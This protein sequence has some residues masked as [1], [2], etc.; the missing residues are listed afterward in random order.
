MAYEHPSV[1]GAYDRNAAFPQ[2]A[3]LVHKAGDFVQAA[4]ANEAQSIMRRRIQRVGDM[5]ARDGDR[6]SGAQVSIDVETGRIILAAGKIYAAGDM[7][8]VPERI[9]EDVDLEGEVSIGIRIV[10]SYLDGD[11]L[12]ALR[13]LHPGSKA[14]GE[15]GAAR[16]VPTVAWSLRSLTE[17]GDYYQVYVA[18]DGTVID[19]TGPSSLATINQQ[20]AAKDVLVTGGNYIATGCIVTA[21]GQ[22]GSSMHFSVSEGVASI[23]GNTRTRTAA[24]RY[25]EPIE[26][27]VAQVGAEPH[28][29]DDGGTGTATIRLLNGP[30][31]AVNAVTVVKRAT[32]TIVRGPVAGTSDPLPHPSVQTIEL[33]VQGAT[34]FATSA[35]TRDG[36][37]ISWAPAGAEPA[38]GS[39][40]TATYTYLETVAPTTIGLDDIVVSGGVTG[41]TVLVNYHWKLP[42]IDRLCLNQ[43]GD[44]LY[45]RGVSARNPK[46]PI[47]PADVLGLADI[48]NDWRGAPIVVNN[49]TAA[50][51]LPMLWRFIDLVLRNADTLALA[52]LEQD[53]DQREPVA[54]NGMFVD[55]LDNDDYR[56]AGVP[57]TAAI[58]DNEIRLAI[59]PTI[60]TVPMT[61]P[62]LLP[63]VDELIIDQPFVTSC[64]KINPY[65]NF[66]PLP[67]KL[68]LTPAVDMW[69][70]TRTEWLS[71]RTVQVT[72][73]AAGTTASEQ[74]MSR[75]Q[76]SA[77]FL[78]EIPVSF[79]IEGFGAGEILAY[80]EF[81]GLDLT[82]SPA[83]VADGAGKI[84]AS[85]VIPEG[86]TA[87][88]K[89]V[90]ARGA[91][92]A[93]AWAEF[94]GNG[95]ID[96]S[97]MQRVVT[98]TTVPPPPPQ[99]NGGGSTQPQNSP[100]RRNGPK[101]R[102]PQ[103]QSFAPL[104]VRHITGV[105]FRICKVGNPARPLAVELVDVRDGD[106][107][108]DVFATAS[109]P[110]SSVS[111][112]DWISARWDWPV[113][114]GASG[115]SAFVIKTDDGEHSISVANVGEFDALRQETVAAQPYAA[116]NRHSSSNAVSWD[117]HQNSDITS[118]IYA[119]RFTATT[120]RA[121]LGTFNLV[122]CSDLRI[123]ATVEIPTSDCAF[124]FE[125]ERASGEIIVLLPNEAHEFAEYVT[126]PV[127][128]WAVLRGT[129]EVSPVL[130]PYVTLLCGKI[131]TTGDYVSRAFVA[132]TGVNVVGRI[133]ALLPAGATLTVS[134]D[135]AND[136]FE[137]MTLASTSVLT[138]G[139][140]ERR[141]Q[142]TGVTAD[143][144]RLKV[145]L[146]GGPAARVRARK[147]RFFSY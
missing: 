8:D 35:Y 141:Y 34:T 30:I 73:S 72:G 118:R 70:E 22:V 129:A 48:H 119:A 87:G 139:A 68:S 144:V 80:F 9:L 77:T 130:Y 4:E 26:W 51:P 85:F 42:R 44:V 1:P 60:I 5:V 66:Y 65:Q 46:P 113:V 50:C 102:D 120:R 135:K 127:K 132:G 147:P 79:L 131:R 59:D 11:D 38:T 124:W 55:P 99:S 12:P 134:M 54:K 97:V 115:L 104:T 53:A 31:A 61:G 122:D 2:F 143:L 36:N 100:S 14:E 71:D 39:S 78:R 58:V 13:G 69:T 47:E 110:M 111:D 138:D 88:T 90:Y 6:Y 84:A 94:T 93:E 109:V 28:V 145:S 91:G 112:G 63:Y 95:I 126:E 24:L 96:I 121:N 137:P 25:G 40:Y 17:P 52:R 76:E 37:N 67:A 86:I 83:R 123:R 15:D 105:D 108:T 140:I 117:H 92:G 142:K 74:L 21:L 62:V 7:R 10:T 64:V 133:Q 146:T 33:V 75:R 32:S 3:G 41:S 114:R 16:E 82:P 49:G 128:L 125:L 20:I 18:R 19:Q 103:A 27:N 136:V 101:E 89:M 45:L 23:Y 57:Q 107:T 29:F 43:Q 98:V 106:P 81:D 116:G 56:D